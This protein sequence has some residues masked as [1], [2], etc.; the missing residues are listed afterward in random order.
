VVPDGDTVAVSVMVVPAATEAGDT[1]SVVV[2]AVVPV[3]GDVEGST[4][5]PQADRKAVAASNSPPAPQRAR[6]RM[7]L[8]A[9]VKSETLVPAFASSA[10]VAFIALPLGSE[11]M[12]NCRPFV[13]AYAAALLFRV[14]VLI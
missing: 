4:V 8:Q 6:R 5:M 10:V 13:R 2:V 9:A 14:A 12:Q 3:L 11:F 7:A 1:E